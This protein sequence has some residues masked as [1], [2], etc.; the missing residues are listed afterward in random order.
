MYYGY[1]D[2]ILEMKEDMIT[3]G[4]SD[5]VSEQD[6]RKYVINLGTSHI[7]RLGKLSFDESKYICENYEDGYNIAYMNGDFNNEQLR[8]L[9]KIYVE[10][11]N[12]LNKNTL[13]NINLFDPDYIKS[14]HKLISYIKQYLPKDA[15]EVLGELD[16]ETY[17][18]YINNGSSSLISLIL[19]LVNEDEAQQC[20]NAHIEKGHFIQYIPLEYLKSENIE[21]YYD[22]F[23]NLLYSIGK[24]IDIIRYEKLKEYTHNDIYIIYNLLEDCFRNI[25]EK[26]SDKFT[27]EY[28]LIQDLIAGNIDLGSE[29]LNKLITTL[30]IDQIYSLYNRFRIDEN[31]YDYD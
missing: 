15:I 29:N 8:E 10:S 3:K 18:N 20:I 2:F 30:D 22:K 28:K 7:P 17:L 24:Y 14:S 11:D 1:D 16:I 19:P 9:A 26:S 27:V 13:I 25:Y 12:P 21:K 5:Q 23:P 4:Y 31:R 6:I